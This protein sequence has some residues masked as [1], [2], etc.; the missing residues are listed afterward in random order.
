MRKIW[1]LFT[2]G[3]CVLAVG[4][5]LAD[6][7]A[8]STSHRVEKNLTCGDAQLIAQTDY[9]T[10]PDVQKVVWTAQSITLKNSHSLAPVPLVLESKPLHLAYYPQ[11]TALDSVIL[12]WTCLKTSSG[13]RYIF[14]AYTCTPSPERP[15]CKEEDESG[16]WDRVLDTSG[17]RLSD[18]QRE[19]LGVNSAIGDHLKLEGTTED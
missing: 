11:G 1:T 18:Q 6:A 10:L 16:N 13:K 4:R 2:A 19:R 17:K 9:V 5:G 8:P 15:D 12:G 3:F 14:L 7:S